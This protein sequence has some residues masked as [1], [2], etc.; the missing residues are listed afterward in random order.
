MVDST[1]SSSS[2]SWEVVDGEMNEAAF[3]DF[4]DAGALTSA[5]TCE[6]EDNDGTAL[7][8]SEEEAIGGS[9]GND[10]HQHQLVVEQVCKV[11]Y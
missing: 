5:A 2:F 3:D 6:E 11:Q 1:S 7:P 4:S 8:R 9:D 10:G